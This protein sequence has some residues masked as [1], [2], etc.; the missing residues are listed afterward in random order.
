MYIDANLNPD[1]VKQ[2]KYVDIYRYYTDNDQ[3]IRLVRSIQEG[4][5]DNSIHLEVAIDAAKNQSMY[6]KILAN[7]YT[8]VCYANDF[9]DGVTDKDALYDVLNMYGN[10]RK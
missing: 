9:F 4:K 7:S 3:I 5:P 2:G 6:A 8:M 10:E 1:K